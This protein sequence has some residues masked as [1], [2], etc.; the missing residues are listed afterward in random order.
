[1]PKSNL[2]KISSNSKI[3]I[4]VTPSVSTGGPEAIF[5]LLYYLINYRGLNCFVYF[6]PSSD[7]LDPV[8][9][10]Y[11]KFNVPIA[12]AIDD[13]EDNILIVPE[14]YNHLSLHLNYVNIQKCI[15]WLSI[16]FFLIGLYEATHSKFTF[17]LLHLY[18]NI[19]NSL[20]KLFPYQI[21]HTDLAN[22]CLIRMKYFDFS[23][24]LLISNVNMHFCQ[25]AYAYNFLE[26]KCL[27]NVFYLTDMFDEKLL[28]VN[29]DIG[30]KKN[31]VAYN[32]SKGLP[33]TE[34]IIKAGG[35]DI[36]F[37]P[38]KNMTK[39]QVEEL[40]KVSKV[41]ID[42]GNHPGRDRLPREAVLNGCCV[43]TSLRGSAGFYEDVPIL[44]NY[45]FSDSID[46]VQLIVELI[47]HIFEDYEASLKD[48]ETY[49]VFSREINYRSS[50]EI[51][52]IFK[53]S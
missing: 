43:I 50:F 52:E 10:E 51:D 32:P 53:I 31:I 29:F 44:S 11:K 23:N 2:F 4:P 9:D 27:K 41:Y 5:R 30:I 46:N 22:E 7:Q 39:F 33:F 34:H 36:V 48:F 37:V 13:I 40:L 28:N 16:D 49:R 26:N 17:R 21:K 35:S 19:K 38:I 12:T 18:I 14:F 15:W 3:F 42:F 8:H 1:M 20:S 45:K 24:E 6:Y 25:S 47:N